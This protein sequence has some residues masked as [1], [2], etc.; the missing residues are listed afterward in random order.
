MDDQVTTPRQELIRFA[1]QLADEDAAAFDMW[2]WLPSCKVAEKY[3]G[4]HSANFRPSNRDV[5]VEAVLYIAHLKHPHEPLT[6]EQKEWFKRCPCG[7]DHDDEES[8]S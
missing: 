2:T 7:E 1:Q 5:I 6:D 8:K 4:S 3:H